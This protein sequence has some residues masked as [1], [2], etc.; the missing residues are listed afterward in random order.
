MKE[1]FRNGSRIQETMEMIKGVIKKSLTISFAAAVLVASMP[2]SAT[3]TSFDAANEPLSFFAPGD[4]SGRSHV[5]TAADA[6]TAPFRYENVITIAGTRIDAIASLVQL[7]NS[8][9]GTR[10]TDNKLERLDYTHISSSEASANQIQ[11]LFRNYADDDTEGFVIFDIQFVLGGTNQAVTLSNVVLTVADIDNNQF[12]QFSG[13]TSYKLSPILDVN[14]NNNNPVS[15]SSFVTPV[16][17]NSSIT[18]SRNTSVNVSVPDGSVMF[19]ASPDNFDY[20][21]RS[22]NAADSDDLFVAQINFASV[23]TLRAKV[24]TF[25]KTSAGLD[26]SFAPFG[27]FNAV[28]PASVTQPSFTVT[29][30]ANSGSGTLPTPTSGTG[31]LTVAGSLTTPG[32]TKAGST[33]AGWNTR[34]DGAG[35][36]Y[37]PGSTILP[38]ANTTLF[39]VWSVAPTPTPTPTPTPSS[40]P[41]TA[42]AATLAK[43]G[44]SFVWSL[45]AGLFAVIAG[46]GFLALSRR[47]RNS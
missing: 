32:I 22:L 40:T 3:T 44:A 13:L 1:K 36:A 37:S 43:T 42:P 2:A 27:N 24:G 20:Q 29:Y 31:A 10:L 41:T 46:T 23:S 19:F 28:T 9:S 7:Q 16:T 33:F 12:V 45:A 4:R 18:T 8:A 30:D 47:Q 39:A 34:A 25:D 5:F 35:V 38:V 26:F 17:G 15:V 14:D 21:D 6:S 11:P